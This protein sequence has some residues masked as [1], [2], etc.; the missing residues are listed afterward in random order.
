M[1][2]IGSSKPGIVQVGQKVVRSNEVDV[3]VVMSAEQ[4]FE[5]ADGAGQVVPPAECHYLAEERRISKREVYR[6]VGADATA[7]DDE[8][9]TPFFESMS[10]ITSCRM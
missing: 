9:R 6:V 2:R 5:R 10:G 7:V 1:R 3:L 8:G 4:V